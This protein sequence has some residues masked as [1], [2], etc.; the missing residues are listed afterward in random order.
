MTLKDIQEKFAG[1]KC[2]PHIH[3]IYQL[4]T[5][6]SLASQ[7][8]VGRVL[9]CVFVDQSI[10]KKPL[11]RCSMLLLTCY[12]WSLYNEYNTLWLFSSKW[13][14]C[15]LN[16]RSQVIHLWSMHTCGQICNVPFLVIQC[17]YRKTH[18]KTPAIFITLQYISKCWNSWCQDYVLK[19]KM[20]FFV[21]LDFGKPISLYSHRTTNSKSL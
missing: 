9:T 20:H 17:F 18:F 12:L 19:N 13:E 1:V 2:T 11:Y 7:F 4:I 6:H 14:S 5:I 15:S 3:Y 8:R 16:P 10:S 21:R